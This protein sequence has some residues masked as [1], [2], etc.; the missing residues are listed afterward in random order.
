MKK[1][2]G[3]S[4]EKDESM[5]YTK[6]RK[7]IRVDGSIHTWV[8]LYSKCKTCIDT[9]NKQSLPK[10]K[11]YYKD[12]RKANKV[13]GSKKSK[14]HYLKNRIEWVKLVRTEIELSCS[15]CGY[16]K[17]LNALDF[18]HSDPREKENTIHSLMKNVPTEDRWESLKVELK[19]CVVLCA[20]CHRE[21]HMKYNIFEEIEKTVGAYRNAK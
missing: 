16:D 10:Y 6:N 15:R 1:C 4:K 2:S 18:H 17:T 21:E 13:A 11:Q 14:E 9:S 12:Y 5:F 20:N 19:K 3:C 8:G 7:K